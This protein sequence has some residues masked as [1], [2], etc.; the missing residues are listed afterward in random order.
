MTTAADPL[1]PAQRKQLLK[2]PPAW[3][4]E[5]GVQVGKRAFEEILAE[6]EALKEANALV[7][8]E[9][10]ALSRAIGEAKKKGESAEG[11]LAEKRTVSAREKESKTALKALENRLVEMLAPV[12]QTTAANEIEAVAETPVDIDHI[13]IDTLQQDEEKHWDDFVKAHPAGTA[14]HLCATRQVIQQSFN[15]QCHYLAAWE[16]DKLIGA[17]P[18]VRLKSPLFGD[19]MV[20]QPFFNYGGALVYHPAVRMALLDSASQKARDLGCSHIEYRDLQAYQDLPSRDDKVAMWLALPD[21][22]EVLWARIGTKVRAQIKRAARFG[23]QVEVGGGELLGDFYRVFAANM[24]D[25]G[26]PV[27]SKAFF[28]NILEAEVGDTRLVVVRKEGKPVSVAF[29]LGFGERMEVPWAS[30]LRSAN[31]YDANM[32]LYWELLSQAC[33]AGYR[34]FDFG[35]S[36]RDAPTFRFKKQ[37]GAEPVQLH[38]HYW[39]R[40][41]GEPPKLN[42]DNPKY[43][44]VIGIWKKLPVWLTRIVGP[45]I[46][47][48]LP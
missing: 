44:L 17:L 26:T 34:I 38:W 21:K 48:Y 40:D 20:S 43:A 12:V 36:T 35:R 3:V 46:V 2:N 4:R 10:K 7:A 39:L 33:T 28:R 22:V 47:K 8:R 9:S 25:L 5:Y 27:Y 29:L 14:Y 6:R 24:R 13:R 11:L 32:Y 15:H 31:Q 37:W 18:L 1:S 41:G 19:F 30:T 16:G 45:S 42:P 23:L